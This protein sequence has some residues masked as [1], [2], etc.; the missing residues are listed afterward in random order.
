MPPKTVKQRES[1]LLRQTTSNRVALV[2]AL[3]KAR[4]HIESAIM[5]AAKDKR[6][7]TVRRI[8]E[9]VYKDI[10]TEYVALQ[11]NLDRWTRG[12][13]RKTSKE[14]HGLAAEDLL[15]T[16]AD[17]KVISF[18]KFSKASMDG[19]FAR[20]HPFN[21]DRLAAVNVQMNPHLTRM[22]D[23]DVRALQNAVVD[24]F[25][26]TKVAG[27]TSVERWNMLQARVLEYADNPTSWKFISRDGRKW[28]R[29]NYFNMLNRSVSAQVARDSYNDTLISENRDLVQ[30]IGGLSSNSHEACRRWVGR[31][32]SLTGA[33]PGY[34]PLSQYISE[35]GFHPNCVHTTVYMSPEFEA[36]AK[37]LDEQK[38]E[39]APEKPRTNTKPVIKMKNA[40]K[41]KP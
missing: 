8:R 15:L 9:G 29:G 34:P 12:S 10:Q 6:F 26:E 35:G 21:A 16:E 41:P 23:T 19:Y 1:L 32:V 18:T 37:V 5:R 17:K 13:I 3:L 33:T 38:G 39:P 40:D 11:G 24:V 22:L 2:E 28:K 7:A 36:T 4:K 14:F 20:I 27:L 25:R 31:V 30:I